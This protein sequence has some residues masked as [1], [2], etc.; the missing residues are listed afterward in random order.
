MRP[1][2]EPSAP[3]DLREAHFAEKTDT[4]PPH[5]PFDA[6]SATEAA[7]YGTCFDAPG[8]VDAILHCKETL[9]GTWLAWRWYKFVDQPALQRLRLSADER[10]FM[11]SRVETMHRMV[12]QKSAWIK[13]H[14]AAKVGLATLD[15]AV[16]M[17]PPTGLEV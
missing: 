9:G 13:P 17:T 2:A 12:G 3:D 14:G 1:L 10:A 15:H 8:P 4:N 16:L 7:R 5:G 11:Q 6:H